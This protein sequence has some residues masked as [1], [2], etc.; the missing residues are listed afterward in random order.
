[1]SLDNI[2]SIAGAFALFIIGVYFQ[3]KFKQQ[4]EAEKEASKK[5]A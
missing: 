3:Y 4:A 1:M 2:V 5:N